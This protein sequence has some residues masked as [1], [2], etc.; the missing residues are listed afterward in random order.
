MGLLFHDATIVFGSVGMAAGIRRAL[1]I[2]VQSK[3]QLP[4]RGARQVEVKPRIRMPADPSNERRFATIPNGD[5]VP[6]PTQGNP[7]LVNDRARNTD[8]HAD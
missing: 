7:R 4:R 3:R 8:E 6:A 5:M 1:L 2:E